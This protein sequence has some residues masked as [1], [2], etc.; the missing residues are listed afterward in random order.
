MI[1]GVQYALAQVGPDFCIVREPI[2]SDFFCAGDVKAGLVIEVDGNQREV[3]VLLRS[4]HL[5]SPKRLEFRKIQ[6]V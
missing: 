1:D 2:S 5:H 6:V 4:D 3:A